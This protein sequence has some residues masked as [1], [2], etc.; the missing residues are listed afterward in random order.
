VARARASAMDAELSHGID[1]GPLHGVPFAHKDLVL[2]QSIH[3]GGSKIFKDF[4]PDHDADIA[5]N[6]EKAVR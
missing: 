5:I 4:V 3:T 2:Y 1:R 6:L